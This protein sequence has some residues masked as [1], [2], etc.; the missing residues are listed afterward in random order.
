MD[1]SLSTE[2]Q[3]CLASRTGHLNEGHQLVAAINEEIKSQR[4]WDGGDQMNECRPPLGY[5]IPKA[6]D[7][8]CVRPSSLHSSPKGQLSKT[9]ECPT[10]EV[11]GWGSALTVS[12]PSSA[13]TKD[14]PGR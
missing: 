7:G 9:C 4:H 12:D 3:E 14:I 8:R 1:G 11:R 5:F 13:N 10:P 6:I 2:D